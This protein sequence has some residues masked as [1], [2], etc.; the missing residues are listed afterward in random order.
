M[1]VLLIASIILACM[2]PVMT[3][4]MKADQ[5]IQT[6]PWKWVQ[7]GAGRN[8]DAYFGNGNT[9][10]AHIGQTERGANDSA[11]LVIN[12][13]NFDDI[14]LFK[15]GNNVL[16]RLRID[17][18]NSSNSLLLG[19][20]RSGTTLGTSTT[21]IGRNNNASGSYSTSIGYYND[22]SGSYSTTVG[23]NNT[24]KGRNSV[25]IGSSVRAPHNYSVAIGYG[26]ASGETDSGSNQGWSTSVGYNTKATGYA[27]AAYGAEA[28]ALADRSLALGSTS[29]AEGNSVDG[30]SVA[31][32]SWAYSEGRNTVSIGTFSCSKGTNSVAVGS[33]NCERDWSSSSSS[34]DKTKFKTHDYATSVN[35]GAY[36]DGAIS[37]GTWSMAYGDYSIAIGSTNKE[38]F[39]SDAGI[40]TY[41]RPGAYRS[42]AIGHNNRIEENAQDS[43][44]LGSNSSIQASNAIAI[45]NSAQVRRTTGIAIGYGASTGSTI[46][47]TMYGDYGIAIGKDSKVGSDYGISIGYN[48]G[49]LNKGSNNIAIGTNACQYVTGSNKT[50]IGTNSGPETG[51]AWASASDTTE[52]IFIGSKSKFN[53][54]PAVLEV[55]NTGNAV[56][57]H[58]G[59]YKGQDASV[60]INGNLIVKG[61]IISHIVD[62]VGNNVS[63]YRVLER[64]GEDEKNASLHSGLIETSGFDYY[65]NVGGATGWSKTSDR[66]LKYVGKENHDG[67]AKLRQLKIFNY[68]FKKDEKKTPRVGVMAQDLQKIFPNAVK[69]GA[70]GFLTIRMEDM[71][72]AVIN[73]I[74]ELD[75]KYKAHENRIM[76]LE[77]EN[78]E[79]RIRL[80]KLESKLK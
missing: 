36:S 5:S 71:F 55:H 40:H 60:V 76:T 33:D 39:T 17:I 35:G 46:D 16:G 43:I 63:D 12:N 24:V 48:A 51:H 69:K 1:V 30:G 78:K 53:N 28:K 44:S 70:D 59:V 20:L 75:A 72:Y 31:I 38:D 27:S 62:R 14:I 73:A 65:F 25:A 66:R 74:K 15:K 61:A 6:S 3:T 26:T 50:C 79:L 13:N 4:K 32:G 34:L 42:I 45:G 54:A 80:E 29:T 41:T 9:Q 7:Q 18:S 77:K 21:S 37:I 22:V 11:K 10:M 47:S 2:A 57:V 67:L 23:Y 56:T 8:V 58:N 64:S 52:R 19:T 68:T 49:T